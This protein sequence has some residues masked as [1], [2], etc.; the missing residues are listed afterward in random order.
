MFGEQSHG[1]LKSRLVAPFQQAAGL[2]AAVLRLCPGIAAHAGRAAQGVFAQ[3]L[4]IQ[5]VGA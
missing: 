2:E 5:P 3:L 1:F 4:F